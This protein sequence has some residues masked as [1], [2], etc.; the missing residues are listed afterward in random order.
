MVSGVFP[1]VEECEQEVWDF[2]FC[3]GGDVLGVASMG[4]VGF[5]LYSVISRDG[6]DLVVVP[7]VVYF[8]GN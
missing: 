8:A 1:G 2:F 5:E 3:E 4:P 6:V 7:V